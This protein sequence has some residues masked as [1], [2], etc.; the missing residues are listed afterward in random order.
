[1]FKSKKRVVCG[2]MAC[3]ALLSLLV[4]CCG[5][6][7]KWVVEPGMSEADFHEVLIDQGFEQVGKKHVGVIEGIGQIEIRPKFDGDGNTGNLREVKLRTE[8]PDGLK[9]YLM[10][11]VG[12]FEQVEYNGQ[13]MYVYDKN[14]TFAAYRDGDDTIR[15]HFE[16]YSS[17]DTKED[18]KEFREA[19]GK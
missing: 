13:T 17:S 6:G 16:E 5:C 2:L 10:D 7:S 19:I 12:G 4:L 1:M 11:E 8:N 15:F 3:I 9:K 18:I 14:G